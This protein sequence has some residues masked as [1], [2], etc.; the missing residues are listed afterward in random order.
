MK[1]GLS[2]DLDAADAVSI[3]ISFHQLRIVVIRTFLLDRM[4]AGSANPSPFHEGAGD[5][6]QE[7]QGQQGHRASSCLFHRDTLEVA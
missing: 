7:E 3:V 4:C 1:S 2:G 5:L 6:E